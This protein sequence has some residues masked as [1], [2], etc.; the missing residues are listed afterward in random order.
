MSQ[1]SLNK[2]TIV[3]ITGHFSNSAEIAQLKQTTGIH[4]CL[5]RIYSVSHAPVVVHLQSLTR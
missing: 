5:N 3:L 1:S 2:P 4:K